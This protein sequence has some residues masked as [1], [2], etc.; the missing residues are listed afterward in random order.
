L[1]L[2]GVQVPLYDAGMTTPVDTSGSLAPGTK[3]VGPS[4]MRNLFT[5]GKK[6]TSAKATVGEAGATGAVAATGSAVATAEDLAS[7]EEVADAAAA[8]DAFVAPPEVSFPATY[9]QC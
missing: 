4:G 3:E 9:V 2:L 1:D 5:R 6:N 8:S 7:K